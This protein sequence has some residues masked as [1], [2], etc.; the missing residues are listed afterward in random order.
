[1]ENTPSQFEWYS[2]DPS[3]HELI[4]FVCDIYPITSYPKKLDNRTQEGSFTGYTKIRSTTKWWDPHTKRLKYCLSSKFDENN[5]RFGKCWSPGSELMLGTNTSTL[6]T[7]KTYLSY[8]PLIKYDIFEGIVTFPPRG[9]PIG[10]T[11]QYYEHHNMSY[12]S[13]SENNSPWNHAF[14]AINRTN[15]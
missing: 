10:I 8:N 13:Q 12:I 1:M 9:T 6:P 3:I 2:K 7:L 14:P 4:T 11:T 5:N 15:I